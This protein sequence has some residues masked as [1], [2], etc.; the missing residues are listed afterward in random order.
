[1]SVEGR[2]K[3]CV[4][5]W[6]VNAFTQQRVLELRQEIAALQS[7]N[8]SYR[9]QKR[10]TD[11]EVNND[12]LRRLRLLAIKEELV[13]MTEPSSKGKRRIYL[14]TQF[15]GMGVG[16]RT[17]ENGLI[18]QQKPKAKPAKGGK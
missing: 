7:E 6:G 18:G 2:L 11:S 1:V 16:F 9:R 4:A 5:R 10:H 8:E 17:G 3:F 15:R 12:D 14:S 13:R